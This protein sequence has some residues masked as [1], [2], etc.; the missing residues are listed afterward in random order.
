MTAKKK[1]E[2]SSDEPK[3]KQSETVTI[4]RSQINFA[5]YNPKNHSKE[6]IAEQKRNFKR[7]G[8]LGGIVWNESTRNLISGHKRV[9]AHDLVYNYDGTKEKDYLIKVEKVNFDL[10]TEKE[11]NIYMDAQNTNTRQ[12]V[13]LLRAILPDIDYQNAGL[14]DLDLSIIGIDIEI[15]S[16]LTSVMN[17]LKEI[18]HNETT[19]EER[20][21]K[22]EKIKAS[23]ES[24]RHGIENKFGEGDP[25]VVLSFKDFNTKAAFMRRFDFDINAKFISG[26]EFSKQIE[27]ID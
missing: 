5:P 26:E 19:E 22:R 24:I 21:A 27:R 4:N 14:T 7:V 3:I 13:D 9:M 12:D 11:Q 20:Q 2:I 23:K 16:G 17:E 1:I 10:K 6:S 25:L 18:N 8:F 15:G